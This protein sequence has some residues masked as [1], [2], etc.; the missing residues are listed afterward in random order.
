MDAYIFLI[1]PAQLLLMRYLILPVLLFCFFKTSAQ[2]HVFAQLTGTPVVTSGWTLTGMASVGNITGSGN[3]E[4]MLCPNQNYQSGAIFYNQPINLNLCNKWIAEFDFRI[5]DGDGADGIAFCFLDVPPTGFVNGGGLGIPASANGLKVCFDTYLNCSLTGTALPK[6]ELRWGAGYDECW[7]Q[8]TVQN[9]S[10]LLSVIRSPNYCHAKIVYNNGNIEVYLNNVLSIIGY[11]QFNFNGYLGFTAATGGFRDNHS[12]KN[13]VIYTDMPP[14]EAGADQ[15]ICSGQSIQLGIAA[16]PNYTY[17]WNPAAGLDNSTVS[18][19]NFSF[20]NNTGSPVIKKFY[21]NTAFS[22]NAGCASMDSVSITVL[23]VPTISISASSTSICSGTNIN[24]SATATNAGSSP[25]FQWKINGQPAGSNSSSFSTTGLNNGD[26]VSCELI[27]N[28]SCPSA[29]S[30]SITINVTQPL[31]PSITISGQSTGCKGVTLSFTSAATNGGSSP[32]YQWKKNGMAVGTGTTYSDNNFQNGD[33]IICELISNE[34]CVTSS[35]ATSNVITLSILQNPQ[36]NLDH[37]PFI[38]EGATRQLH[39]GNFNNYLWQDGSTASNFTLSTTGIYYVTVTDAQGCKGSD[40]VKITTLL[41]APRKFLPSDSSFCTFNSFT[42]TSGNYDSYLWNTGSVSNSIQ[43]TQPG[44]YWLEVVSDQGC[45]GR[46]SVVYNINNC[47]FDIY[48][49]TGFTPDG[50][51]RNDIF[52]PIINN[53]VSNYKFSVYNRWGQLVFSTT[54]PARGWD[55][56]INGAKQPSAI[57]IWTCTYRF[58]GQELKNDKGT[59]LLIR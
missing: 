35:T 17:N 59:V 11:Q 7:S 49:P 3:S 52:K 50:N 16:N 46:D 56:T 42:L 13:V 32:Q 29:T 48:F 10:G 38:C 58:N 8:P 18:N 4:I 34:S 40:T 24:F 28:G 44:T 36:V 25:V 53:T 51:G 22:N 33:Q 23:P 14:S 45:K 41:P 57:F 54:N 47:N 26:V 2:T 39:A 19:P 6:L 20:V 9:T 5:Y 55:G 15:T 27:S 30:N 1:S 31:T 43:I 37:S 21:V 12:I